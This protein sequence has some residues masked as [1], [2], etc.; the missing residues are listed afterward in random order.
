M[1]VYCQANMIVYCA[2]G[3]FSQEMSRKRELRSRT[4][5]LSL[6]PEGKNQQ[7]GLRQGDENLRRQARKCR[8][9]FWQPRFKG[10]SAG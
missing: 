3:Q 8:A 5:T 4:V 2:L 9:R 1:N 6:Q 7:A 10:C